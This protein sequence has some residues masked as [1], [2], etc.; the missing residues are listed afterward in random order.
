MIPLERNNG[1]L[2]CNPEIIPSN[3]LLYIYAPWSYAGQYAKHLI[4]ALATF[5]EID[6]CIISI[7]APIMNELEVKY[8]FK[9][10]GKGETFWIF[11]GR[12]IH[13]FWDIRT[14]CDADRIFQYSTDLRN[15]MIEEH[16]R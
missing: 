12:I 11:N 9:S 10:E 16:N 7:D 13:R 4:E 14:Q 8:N 2:I 6:I 5:P 15:K 1:T 3:C